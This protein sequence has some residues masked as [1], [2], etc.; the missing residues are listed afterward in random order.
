MPLGTCVAEQ[1]LILYIIYVLQIYSLHKCLRVELH[2]DAQVG[3]VWRYVY[4]STLPF[5]RRIV[6]ETRYEYHESS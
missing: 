4:L 5:K 3:E 6:P 1:A 2:S